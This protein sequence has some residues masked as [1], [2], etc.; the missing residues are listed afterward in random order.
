MIDVTCQGGGAVYHSEEVHIGKRLRCARCDFQV[1]I[2]WECRAITQP[3]TSSPS[4]TRV[5]YP[6]VRKTRWLRPIDAMAAGLGLG[7]LAVSLF[8]L[9]FSGRPVPPAATPDL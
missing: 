6:P 3:V 4:Q 7:A 2:V 5:N 1:P 8:F 9:H